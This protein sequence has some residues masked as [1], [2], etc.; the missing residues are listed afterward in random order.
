MSNSAGA[1]AALTLVGASLVGAGA[2]LAQA[3]RPD[4][5]AFRALYEELV[6]TN[7]TLSE[8]SCT[9]A[10][11]RMAARLIA[12]GLPAADVR[13]LVPDDRPKDGNLAAVLR[14][15]D[16]A[17]EPILLL[18]HI[19]VV[20]AK[21]EDWDR[22][23]FTL[24]EE[25]GYFYARGAA[26]DKAQAAVWVDTLVRLKQQGFTPRRDIKIAL[27]CGEE[28]SDTFNGVSWLLENHRDALAAAFA[29]NEGARGRLDA[30]GN[31]VALE[32]QA[33]EKVYQDYRLEITNPGGHSSRPVPD[34]AIY[35]LS[36][37]LSRLGAYA[38]P[39]EPN[40]AVQAYFTALAGVTPVHA[41]DMRA[42]AGPPSET[43]EAA[44]G[45]L[46]AADAAWNSVLRTTCVATMVD[47]G[48]APN[49]LPQSAVANVNCRILPG[50]DPQE[51]RAELDRVLADPGI[52]VT[53]PGNIDPTSPPPPLTP[54]ILDPIVAAAAQ[55][56]PG[57]PVVPSM[58][59]GATD[60][61]FTN[62]AGVPTYGVT[63]MFADPDG[64]GV[65]GLNE[66][67]RVRSLYEGRDFLFELVKAYAE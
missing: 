20:E 56:W 47:A 48:H 66:R 10:S 6:E 41:D 16:P 21:R 51:V 39:T 62:A 38:F 43:R 59:T 50:H 7:T 24:V 13:V 28:T 17:A 44:A 2:A 55:Q 52:A 45:R 31:R 3:P 11:E 26:D 40:A 60:G 30:Q 25:D 29:L 53:I 18:A 1:L 4:Q 32:I 34:N 37:A 5:T 19:D 22:D 27:T 23:P 58:S 12:A 54:A 33:G 46:S 36:N 67:I 65:H 49:A 42:I 15:S 64:G 63:G 35:R 9:L 57:V 14:G 61:R 8:G